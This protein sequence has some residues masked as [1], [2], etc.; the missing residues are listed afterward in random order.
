[1]QETPWDKLFTPIYF[2]M[3]EFLL[4][5]IVSFV[6]LVNGVIQIFC[7]GTTSVN[8]SAKGQ[9]Y[10]ESKFHYISQYTVRVSLWFLYVTSGGML[11][12]FMLLKNAGSLPTVVKNEKTQI[13]TPVENTDPNYNLLTDRGI[14]VVLYFGGIFLVTFIFYFSL[15]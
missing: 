8:G 7:G 2:Y 14:L 12:L 10:M 4:I 13:V 1:M 11:L 6:I 3:T 5:A 9:T 15:K